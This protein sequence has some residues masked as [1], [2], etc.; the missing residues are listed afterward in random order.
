[1]IDPDETDVLMFFNGLQAAYRAVCGLGLRQRLDNP[2]I[3]AAETLAIEAEQALL[4]EAGH[5]PE[6]LAAA[7]ARLQ[8]V[9]KKLRFEG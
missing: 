3:D 8:V 6:V 7:A 5:D 1:M 2:A 4:E 9:L